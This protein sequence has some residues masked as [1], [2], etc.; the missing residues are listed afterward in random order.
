[1]A[2]QAGLLDPKG[3]ASDAGTTLARAGRLDR[4]GITSL[5][6]IRVL[7][8]KRHAPFHGLR[9]AYG[10]RSAP[11]ASTRERRHLAIAAHE[12]QSAFDP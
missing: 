1:M 9:R 10:Q 5:S 2:D 11:V 4:S 8:R 6:D 3:R 7:I 12:R